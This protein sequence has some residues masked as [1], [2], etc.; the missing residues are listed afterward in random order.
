MSDNYLTCI[1][2]KS[3]LTQDPTRCRG[4]LDVCVLSTDLSVKGL[5]AEV[6]LKSWLAPGNDGVRTQHFC[7]LLTCLSLS[8]CWVLREATDLG[9]L[10]FGKAE[11]FSS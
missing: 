5:Q 1:S 6:Y 3:A 7:F 4:V 8:T 2:V 10:A 11:S 9:G